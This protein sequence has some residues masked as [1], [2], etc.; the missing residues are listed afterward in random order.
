MNLITSEAALRLPN[1]ATDVLFFGVGDS[2]L[3]KV[4][5]AR[6][7]KGVCAILLGGDAS[8]L[9]A[10]L[11]RRLPKAILLANEVMVR[12]DL[13]KVARYAEKPSAGL[14]LTL[15]IR[16]TPLQRRIW[17]QI[18]AI[19]V[20]RTM[21]YMQLAR[22]INNAYPKVAA[23]VV[24]NACAA[25]PIALAVPCHR[26]IRTDG[27]LAGYRWGIER[28]RDLIEKEARIEKEALA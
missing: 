22:L 28:K 8:E 27:E 23:R 3:G 19:P 20:G 24:A 5:L 14:D 21:S 13:A 4:L 1:T 15:D 25:N 11:A 16:G 2:A 18:C 10:D 9:E 7:A 26:V 6:S 17:Q 12:D